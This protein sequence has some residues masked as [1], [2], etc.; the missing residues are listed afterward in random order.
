MTTHI[1]GK[2]LEESQTFLT[3]TH[4]TCARTGKPEPSLE[5]MKRVVHCRLLVL[6][7]M[8]GKNKSFTRL[9]IRQ[10]LAKKKNAVDQDNANSIMGNT[11]EDTF[12]IFSTP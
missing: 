5:N 4:S 9:L 1:T 2:T 12:K 8:G 3:M 10:D 11:I 6:E 7:A